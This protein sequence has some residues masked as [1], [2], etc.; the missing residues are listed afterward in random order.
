MELVKSSKYSVSGFVKLFVILQAALLLAPTA[1]AGPSTFS[2]EGRLYD[3]SGNSLTGLVNF[4][5]RIYNPAGTCLI[6]EEMTSSIDLTASSGY[7]SVSV[8][9]NA[10]TAAFAGRTP[11]TVFSNRASSITGSSV[12]CPYSPSISDGRLL[13]VV[14]NLQNG[15]SITLSPK[16][17][18]GSSPFS[19]A[20]DDANTVGGLTPSSLLQVNPANSI[21]SQ[22]TLENI[23]STSN[24]PLLTSLLLG[25]SSKYVVASPNGAVIPSVSTAPA[26]P[27]S[28]QIWFNPS[29]NGFQYWNGTSVQQLGISGSGLSSLTVGSSLQANGAQ[30]GTLTSSGTIDLINSGV[31]AGSYSK[32]TVNSKGLVTY[33]SGLS[34]SD[35]PILSTA[36]KVLGNAIS[37]GSIGGSTSVNTSGNIT[38]TGTLSAGSLSSGSAVTRQLQIFDPATASTHKV[39]I[40]SP[41]LSSDYSLSLPGVQGASGTVLSNDGSGN[42]NWTN[43][44]TSVSGSSLPSGKVWIGSA[45]SAASPVTISG[46]LQLSVAGSG[47]ITGVQ[48]K[49]VSPA[50]PT[51]SGQT[52][53]WNQATAQYVPAFLSMADIRSTAGT[54]MFQASS[55]SSAQSLF[56]S[57]LTDQFTCQNISI[58]NSQV[59]WS[60]ISA[61]LI[62]AGP[63]TGGSTSPTFRTLTAADLPTGA[64]SQWNTV[65]TTIN[66]LSGSVGIG[67]ASPQTILDV[68]ATG[69]L[70]AMLLPR[71]SSANRP[72][73]INGMIRY[74]TVSNKA[75]TYANSSWQ[76]IDTSYGSV[77]AFVNGGNA[78]G[79]ASAL[80][81]SDANSLSLITNGNPRLL[82][83]SNGNVGIGTTLAPYKLTLGAMGDDGAILAT[84][85]YGVG[86]S[87]GSIGPTTSLIWT[88]KKAAFRAG[89]AS[90]IAFNDS[91][92]GSYSFAG[93][94][95][96]VASGSAST[97]FGSQNTASGST[98]MAIGYS[99]NA[100]GSNSTALGSNATAI[101]ALSVAFGYSVSAPAYAETVV[102]LYNAVSGSEN[103]NSLVAADPVFV[104][105]NGT[106][107]G[108]LS[109]AM[110]ILHNGSVGIGSSFPS[111]TLDVKGHVANSGLTATVGSCG[112][113]P[114]NAGNDTRGRVTIG[115][116]SPT[117][118][119]ISFNTSY[120]TPPHCVITAYGGDPGAIRWWVVTTTTSIVLNF[121]AT[122]TSLQQFEYNCMQ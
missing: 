9:A 97:S 19:I 21:L 34:E 39:T 122:P 105:G 35:L 25:T 72:S 7:Y 78:F 106:S 67:T 99:N 45:S 14:V 104:V 85:T 49:A 82:I 87:M 10:P 100:F 44:A 111:A 37:S 16:L 101:G 29:A 56:W 55:C 4:N 2:Y 121:S 23:F 59:A 12:G 3:N 40:V 118:C 119:T 94:Y 66:Y 107:P 41:T 91:A 76:S 90:N 68:Y 86:S 24:Y 32:V 117:A 64:I 63:S 62:F 77:G 112:T 89:S 71:D 46:D 114:A 75:E 8:G 48:G 74:N 31:V 30:S 79:T 15:S 60:S 109:S 36:G 1:H 120:A 95:E 113:A 92:V 61:N 42:L 5:L 81:T 93:G 50:S 116:G 6:Y 108:A 102:G 47:T 80:G 115:T 22:A 38:T 43:P 54:T 53:R 73:G 98:S 65:S 18:I 13:E 52:L 27:A 69:S 17:S 84:G 96:N 58:P 83:N 11:A 103:A 51:V 33:G 26:S 28:G 88:P 110:T 70:S 20:A 57:S